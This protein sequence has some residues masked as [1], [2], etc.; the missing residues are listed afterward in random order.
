MG[1]PWCSSFD[2][3]SRFVTYFLPTFL[4]LILL[5]SS[6]VATNEEG[7]TIVDFSVEGV[8]RYHAGL[9]ARL[10]F[11]DDGV[12][13]ENGAWSAAFWKEFLATH[14]TGDY[15]ADEGISFG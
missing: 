2:G 12:H 13:A 9:L 4:V 10:K 8:V 14:G 5:H 7:F 15:I 3:V 11:E 1:L 6:D